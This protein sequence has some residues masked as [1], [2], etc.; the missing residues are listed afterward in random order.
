MRSTFTKVHV[1]LISYSLL[2]K[3]YVYFT[4]DKYAQFVQYLYFVRTLL[5]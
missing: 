1:A 4:I 3:I 2:L 5:I